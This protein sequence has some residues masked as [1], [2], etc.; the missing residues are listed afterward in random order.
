MKPP[1]ITT[2]RQLR[3]AIT[4]VVMINLDVQSTDVIWPE[5]DDM[6]AVQLFQFWLL[7]NKDAS[8][9]VA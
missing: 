3:A 1:M 4:P 8:Q 6:G 9:P 2:T 5:L 7:R